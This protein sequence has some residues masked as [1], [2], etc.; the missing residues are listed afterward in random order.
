M[1]LFDRLCF[2]VISTA[3][4]EN[5]TCSCTGVTQGSP[6]LRRPRQSHLSRR[7]YF[8]G[9]WLK[10]WEAINRHS[11]TANTRRWTS[12]VLM[13]TNIKTI[14]FNVSCLLVYPSASR[15]VGP[16][17]G[18]CWA[19]VV[20]DEPTSVHHWANASC[21]PGQLTR[22]CFGVG[23]ASHTVTK[24]MSAKLDFCQ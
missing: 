9:L 21:F 3:I 14:L 1:C 20:D 24:Q 6:C 17:L 2:T 13:W 11:P 16:M 18:W 5:T 4:V 12:V 23:P 10:R 7:G 15:G 22:C 19:S 8:R